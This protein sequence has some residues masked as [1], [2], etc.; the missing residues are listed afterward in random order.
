MPRKTKISSNKPDEEE[1]KEK[2]ETSEKTPPPEDPQ[3]SVITAENF[4]LR[5]VSNEME[6][7]YLDYAMSVIVSRA[8]PDVRDGLKPVH[9]RILFAMHELGLSAGAKYRKSA[10]VVGDVLAKYHPHG[11]SAV[12]DSMVRLAQDFAMRYPMVDGQGNFGSID[13]DSAAA[14]R[15]TEAK[16]DKISDEMLADIEKETVDFRDNYDGRLKEPSVLPAKIPQLL[17]NGVSGIAVGM[18]TSIPPHNLSETIDAVIHLSENPDATIEDLMEHIKGPDFPTAGII[19]DKNAIKAMYMN[20]RGGIVCRAKAE[21][22]ERKTGRFDIVV[23]EIP[24]Q[25]NKSVLVSK[26]ADLVRDKKIVGISDIRDQSNREGIEVMIELKKD[27]YPKKILNQL[28]KMTDLQ[29][30]FHMNMIALVEG[31]QPRLLDLK[32]VLEYFIE[33]RKVTITRRTQY[34]LKVAMARAHILEGLKKALDHIDAVIKTIRESK[35]KEE[36]HV[37]LM[38]KFK[39]SDLQATAILEMRLQTLAGL[40]RKKILDELKEKLA[41]IDHLEGILKDAKKI[42]KIMKDELAEI[43]TRYGDERRTKIV[44]H[45]VS[46]IAQK[47]TIPNEPMVVVLTR[48]NYIKRM[49]PSTFRTQHRGGKG[50]LGMATKD[51]DEIKIICHT[52]NHEEILFFTNKGRVFKLPVYEIPQ[53]SR[54]AKGQAI[55][56]ILQL[57]ESE[58]VS[59]MLNIS[60]KFTGQFLFMAT[61]NGTVKKTPVEDFENVRRSGLIAIKLRDGDELEWVKETNKGDQIFIATSNGKSIR[62]DQ[63]DARPMGRPSMGVRGIRLKNKDYCVEMD[64]VKNPNE[65]E[66]LIVMGNG[67]GKCTKITNYRLQGRGGSGV[68]TARVTAKTGEVI[69]AKVFDNKADADIILV[70]KIGQVIR[71][72]L[73]DTPS[74][75]RATQGVYL[76]RMDKGDHV[77]S[78][79]LIVHVNDEAEAP[80][81]KDAELKG[82]KSATKADKKD[83]KQVALL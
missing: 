58:I 15:Y 80:A 55:V 11:D 56:N 51:E 74:Q 44:A 72:N 43:K 19:Y 60:D 36:A 49:P 5:D 26:M 35:T 3:T 28:Y 75:G 18:A 50:V 53:A 8:L 52:R 63:E 39:L 59:S 25:V 9:R 34:E 81:D 76:M 12:Y 57:Q 7:S 13:G 24:Y 45:A 69:G 68:K 23:T 42:L 67:L 2:K 78:V 82:K 66:V 30:T 64:V 22:V 54:I 1:P 17:L 48:E 47:D 83:T 29:T 62:F 27:A 14:M 79:S 32:Q 31:L 73:K 41:L 33:H 77:A 37:E 38:S 21:I 40:E 70:S 71:L 4:P 65:A 10:A 6:E 20:G 16:M 46:E 61:R